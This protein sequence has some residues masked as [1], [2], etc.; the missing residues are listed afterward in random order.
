MTP[1]QTLYDIGHACLD[2]LRKVAAEFRPDVTIVQGDT[3]TVFF[4]AL[5]TFFQQGRLAH[6]EAGL[7]SMR[8][9][10]RSP[11]RCCAA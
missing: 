8:S 3:A 6:V 11:R 4:A 1:G 10:P 7:R 9:G 5:V 2:G